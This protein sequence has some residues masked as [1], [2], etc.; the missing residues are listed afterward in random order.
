MKAVPGRDRYLRSIQP[1]CIHLFILQREKHV[2]R[3]RFRARLEP[4]HQGGGEHHGRENAGHREEDDGM[5]GR[6][7]QLL[8]DIL[9]LQSRGVLR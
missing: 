3:H 7:R 1:T 6:V 4:L 5:E 2:S 9:V 8:L